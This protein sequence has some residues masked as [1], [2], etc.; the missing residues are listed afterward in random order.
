MIRA[1][2][3]AYAVQHQD[4]ADYVGIGATA[5]FP[6]RSNVPKIVSPRL[7]KLAIMSN[8]TQSLTTIGLLEN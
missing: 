2:S 5:H 3:M 7:R 6:I 1:S 8:E 4:Q